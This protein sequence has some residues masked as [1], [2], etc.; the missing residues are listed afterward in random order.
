M[1]ERRLAVRLPG[2][3]SLLRNFIRQDIE[4]LTGGIGEHQG[5]GGA[6]EKVQIIECLGDGRLR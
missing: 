6:L 3:R 1:R 2:L 4:R 5:L